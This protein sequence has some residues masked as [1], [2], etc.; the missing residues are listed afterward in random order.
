M[1]TLL[2][3]TYRD[4]ETGRQMLE[5]RCDGE[6][7]TVFEPAPSTLSPLDRAWYAAE[8]WLSHFGTDRDRSLSW[9]EGWIVDAEGHGHYAFTRTD[10][11]VFSFGSKGKQG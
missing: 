7:L 11:R 6:Q 3:S 10:G 9:T 8:L 1:K 5:A 2:V 4:R